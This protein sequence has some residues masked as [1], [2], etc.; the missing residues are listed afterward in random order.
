MIALA[1][2][3]IWALAAGTARDWFARSPKR[4]ARMRAGGGIVMI[5]LGGTLALTGSKS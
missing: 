1:S 5:G 3:G 4:I 2:D